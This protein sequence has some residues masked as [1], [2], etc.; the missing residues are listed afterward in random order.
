MSDGAAMFHSWPQRLG[1]APQTGIRVDIAGQQ[2]ELWRAGELVRA[3]PVSSARA[4]VGER[5]GSERTP[6]GWHLVRARIGAG[7]PQ[8][9]VF[10]G[11]RPTGEIYSPE[12]ARRHP[13]RDWILSRILWLSGLE[14]GRNRLGAVDTMR[15]FIYIHGCPDGE[16]MGVAGSHGCVRMRNRDVIELF[17]Q[18]PAGTPVLIDA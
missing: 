15:R 2:L 17:E 14:P 4:G 3:Y 6:R 10:V 7:Q 12:L 1:P 9:A 18:V 13:R 5:S 11:R 8:G 16:P